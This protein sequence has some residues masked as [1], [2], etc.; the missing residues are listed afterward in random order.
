MNKPSVLASLLGLL[1][2]VVLSGLL[3]YP[4]DAAEVISTLGP[5]T[6]TVTNPEREEPCGWL[7]LNSDETYENGYAWTYQGM[8]PPYYGA[9]AEY[10]PGGQPEVCAIVLDLTTI[11]P[12]TNFMDAYI[13][14]DDNG[15]PGSVL[16]MTPDVY[17]E[18]VARWPAISRHVVALE[19]YCYPEGAWWA[20]YWGHWR[21]VASWWVGADVEGE[22]EAGRPFNNIA[23]GL[24]YPTG[25][26]SVDVVFGPTRSIGIGI[27][28]H[29]LLPS[30]APE[31]GRQA[32]GSWGRIK[33]LYR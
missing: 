24:G 6:G 26:Q 21:G 14:D 3:L 28:A 19:P 20:G 13:W 18:G 16:C 10:F 4:A 30:A 23:P 32:L 17:I 12:R 27:L 29:T 5:G 11:A 15:R 22:G 31:E 7:R 1:L 25:W 8:V 9:F 33:G 2:C